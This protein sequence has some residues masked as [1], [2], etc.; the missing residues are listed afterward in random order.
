MESKLIQ[1]IRL[2]QELNMLIKQIDYQLE[3]P[4]ECSNRNK[5]ICRKCIY[6]VGSVTPICS[7]IK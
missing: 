7:K 2:E 1:E 3:H 5:A 6:N 4:I